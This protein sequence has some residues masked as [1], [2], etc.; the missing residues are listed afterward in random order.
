VGKPVCIAIRDTEI[1]D[2]NPFT[3]EERRTMILESLAE[4]GDLVTIVV[5]PDIDEIAY[6]RKVGYRVTEVTLD[7]E[8]EGISGTG[9]RRQLR[10]SGQL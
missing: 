9:T 1:S 6:G 10:E 8:I 7:E 5:I 3:V 4:Y 2:D